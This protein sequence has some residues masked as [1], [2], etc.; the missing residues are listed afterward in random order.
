MIPKH[1][2]GLNLELNFSLDFMPY[3]VH[4][5]HVCTNDLYYRKNNSYVVTFT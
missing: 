4:I 3:G 2:L 1:K 5:L